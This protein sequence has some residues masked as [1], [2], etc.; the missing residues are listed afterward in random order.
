MPELRRDDITLHYEDEGDG[1]PLILLAGMLSDSASW[2]SVAGPL[3]RGRRLIRPDNRTTG[4]TRPRDAE[5]SVPIMAADVL[6]LMDHLGLERAHLAGHSMGGMLAA[7]IAGAAPGRVASLSLLATTQRRTPRTSAVFDTLL[8][9]RRQPGGEALWL[10]ALYPWVFAPPFFKD[11]EN[12]RIAL[13]AAL[14]YP[15]A[16][17][18][19]AMEHQV[20]MLKAHAT[21]P[22]LEA[23]TAP[24]QVIY[25]GEDLLTPPGPA[26]EGFAPIAHAEHHVIEGAGHSIHWEAP[27]A[28]LA[29]LEDFLGRHGLD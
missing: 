16:Q 7:H 15:H 29:L 4:R 13:E 25:A 18:L 1:P 2:G 12:T 21:R 24:T 3:A 20:A 26:R 27:Q 28:V 9:I 17:D 19:A 10:R 14:A 5:T 6:A 8:D 22:A 23:I 11:P